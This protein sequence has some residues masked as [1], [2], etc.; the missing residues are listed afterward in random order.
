MGLT[1][2]PVSFSTASQA[3]HNSGTPLMTPWSVMAT[4]GMSNSAARRTM[5]FTCVMPSS[6]EYSV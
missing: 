6:R 5:S 2:L 4:A 3:S 1:F